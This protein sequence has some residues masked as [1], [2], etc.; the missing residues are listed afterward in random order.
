M[1]KWFSFTRFSFRGD[2]LYR[3][4]L[5]RWLASGGI[6][7]WTHVDIYQAYNQG[8]TFL[9]NRDAERVH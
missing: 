4:T 8:N 1:S 3:N 9:E 5:T 7:R 2:V 6:G